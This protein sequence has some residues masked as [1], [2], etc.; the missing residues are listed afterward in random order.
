MGLCLAVG[1]FNQPSVAVRVA[2]NTRRP[3]AT[4]GVTRRRTA[5]ASTPAS[6]PS[7]VQTTSNGQRDLDVEFAREPAPGERAERRARA[8]AARREPGLDQGEPEHARVERSHASAG[9][10]GVARCRPLRRADEGLADE[11]RGRHPR[12]S[13]SSMGRDQKPEGRHRGGAAG[14]ASVSSGSRYGAGENS[15]NVRGGAFR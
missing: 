14:G 6:I 7:R 2:S 15:A 1:G 9:R 11:R 10:R 8:A 3:A 12:R 5:A 4:H 13:R